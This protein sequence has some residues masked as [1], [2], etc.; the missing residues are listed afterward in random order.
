MGRAVSVEPFFAFSVHVGVDA[1][2]CLFE[3]EDISVTSRGDS[4]GP[5]PSCT[6]PAFERASIYSQNA[7]HSNIPGSPNCW[8]KTKAHTAS[9]PIVDPPGWTRAYKTWYKAAASSGGGASGGGASG[10]GGSGGGGA[11][12][13][14]AGKWA[15]LTGSGRGMARDQGKLAGSSV[16]T[17][18]DYKSQC[19]NGC[20]VYKITKALSQDQCKAGAI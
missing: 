14:S 2:Q 5:P 17:G 20:L 12:A 9:S 4:A 18:A 10:G 8:F 1:G 7:P 15:I 11:A 13:A 16:K 19:P 3:V 6:G